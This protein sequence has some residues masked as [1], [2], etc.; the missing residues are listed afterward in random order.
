MRNVSIDCFCVDCSSDHKTVSVS[1]RDCN[2]SL[3]IQLNTEYSI[4]N[5]ILN[6]QLNTEYV[7]NQ[8]HTGLL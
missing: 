5:L 1:L 3:N 8:A 7:F 4:F 2:T 6:I